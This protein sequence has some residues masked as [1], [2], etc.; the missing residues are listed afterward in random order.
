M[1]K[2][3]Q[4]RWNVG[5]CVDGRY[6]IITPGDVSF[7]ARV[8]ADVNGIDTAYAVAALPELLRACVDAHR[9][10]VAYNASRILQGNQPMEHVNERIE[11]LGHA[12][13]RAERRVAGPVYP[14]ETEP[15]IE[16][17]EIDDP[18]MYG[19][20][21]VCAGEYGDGWTN[22]TCNQEA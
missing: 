12:I 15:W 18:G 19:T 14:V 9:T 13:A 10:L 21:P 6:R 3:L 4:A 1:D 17:D 16:P 8:V 22:C 5:P 7:Q 20:C 11:Q 2:L